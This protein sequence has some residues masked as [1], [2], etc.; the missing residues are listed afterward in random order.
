MR[1]PPAALCLPAVL[2]TALATA[3][4]STLLLAL[5][6]GPAP[7][8]AGTPPAASPA[9]VL[10][11]PAPAAPALSP[12]ERALLSILDAG[13]MRVDSLVRRAAGLGDGPQARALSAQAIAMKRDTE[14]QYLERLSF[15]ARLR[16]NLGLALQA[17]ARAERIR[18]PAAP[19][20]SSE[21]QRKPEASD[22]G[23]R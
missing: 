8:S 23:A 5:A 21:P 10:V 3:L 1:L 6:K 14:L 2:V 4:G 20:A 19:A 18:H 22:G 17:D 12:D 15:L 9:V 7:A 16:G 13:R 11:A